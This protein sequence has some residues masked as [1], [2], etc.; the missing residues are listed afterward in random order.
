MSRISSRDYL[1][2]VLADI[3]DLN[4]LA[5][6]TISF[7]F[8]RFVSSNKQTVQGCS[9]VSSKLEISFPQL[10]WIYSKTKLRHA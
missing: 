4:I 10:K 2:A 9:I 5:C 8:E 7:N 3:E 6:D 1:I